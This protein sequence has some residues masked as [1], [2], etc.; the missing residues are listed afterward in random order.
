MT[1]RTEKSDPAGSRAAEI[2]ALDAAIDA[3]AAV[4]RALAQ[5]AESRDTSEALQAWARHIVV[6]AAPPGL[7]EGAPL[8]VERDWG[9]ARTYAVRHVRAQGEDHARSL[10]DLQDVVWTMIEGISRALAD[11]AETDE[12]AASCLE[13]LRLAAGSRPDELKRTALETVGELAEILASKRRDQQALARRLGERVVALRTEL[14]D[15]RREAELDSLTQLANRTVL[16]RSVERSVQMRTLVDEP[17]CLLMIDVDGFK[18]VND[19]QGHHGGDEALRTLARALV[20][21]FP[22]RSDLVARYGGDEFAVVLRHAVEED[23]VRLA[24]VFLEAVRTLE[25]AGPRG[26][27]RL[28]ASVGVAEL[29][30]AETAE[31]AIARA[32]AALYAAKSGGRDRVESAGGAG[33]SARAA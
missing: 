33:A 7:A 2:A 21:A 15:A 20:L 11:G 29:R 31:S 23:A 28:T 24:N 13:R 18:A 27:F 22:R 19:Q 1:R 3:F 8:P 30:P 9:G 5:T 14:E 25:I 32:D 12:R 10:A 16:E 4:L 6:L 26:P 17:S